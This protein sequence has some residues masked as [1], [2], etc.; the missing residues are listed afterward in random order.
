M[1][2]KKKIQDEKASVIK[3]ICELVSIPSV[4]ES[5]SDGMPFGK[6][7]AEALQHVLT[8]GQSM[9]FHTENFDNY[10][11][12]IDFGEGEETL[13]ILCHADVVPC[14]DGWICDPY[15]P[16]IIDG[17]LYGRGVLDDKGPLI[18]CLYAMKILKEL[19]LPLRKKVRLIVG[20]NEETNWECMNYYFGKKKLPFPDIAFT[21]DAEFPLK[22]AEKGVL[23]Y[24]L[25][26][27]LTESIFLS[28]GN[29]VNSVP[30]YASVHL[31]ISYLAVL[32]KEKADLE[33]LTG[34]RF[35]IKERDGMLLLTAYGKAAH[36]ARPEI[37]IN[38]V[39]AIMT[40]INSLHLN[41]D[42]GTAAAF[43]MQ[44]IGSDL[45]GHRIGAGYSDEESGPLT[46]NVGMVSSENGRLTFSIDN[47]VPVTFSCQN[48]IDSVKNTIS[49]TPFS[50]EQ[51]SATES[52][53]VSRDS[54]LVTTLMDVYRRVTGDHKAQPEVDGGC[55]YA[56]TMPNCVAFG[57]LLPGQ[58]NTM[59]EKNEGLEL[60]LIDT[61]M[62]L[63]L[64]AIYQLAK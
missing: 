26:M 27:P 1:N 17:V 33:K 10:A 9:G 56:R 2:Y 12:H 55:T 18:V 14:G 3:S 59:H 45:D 57:A 20:T 31:P 35:E 8:L 25:V 24:Q 52:I 30:E 28:G 5:P 34:C 19:N 53:L 47:R 62:E 63:Y 11:G 29:A 21:P 42:L 37:G 60:T 44:Y 49:G 4:E 58:P 38:A 40:A 15:H 13:G 46:F 16:E 61:W 50:M 6:G 43:Y 36:A 54:F 64:E 32:E 39:T 22:Y 41:G 48:V 7:P 51:E 23:Q